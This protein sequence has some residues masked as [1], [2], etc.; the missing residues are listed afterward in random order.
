MGSSAIDFREV[1]FWANDGILECWAAFLVQEIDRLHVIPEWL[2]DVRTKWYEQATN[3]FVGTHWLGLDTVVTSVDRK[4]TVLKLAHAALDTV[5]SHDDLVAI[6][7]DRLPNMPVGGDPDWARCGLPSVN[8]MHVGAAF[9]ALL[10]HVPVT[11]ERQ[12]RA[13]AVIKEK[14]GRFTTA[15]HLHPHSGH[16]NIGEARLLLATGQAYEVRVQW[17]QLFDGKTLGH[18]SPSTWHGIVAGID[19]AA[20]DIL[21]PGALLVQSV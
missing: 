3:N 21:V 17:V 1:F 11:P 7:Y 10:L 4:K 16:L 6:P 5:C 14:F 19:G 18:H 20:P 9:I 2:A 12:A 8:I 15:V 13:V